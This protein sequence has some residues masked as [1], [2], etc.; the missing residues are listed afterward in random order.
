MCK[1]TSASA[2]RPG[3]DIDWSTWRRGF[4]L[5]KRKVYLK[6]CAHAAMAQS[7]SAAAGAYLSVR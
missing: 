3:Q 6:S 1:P 7:V 2:P 4:P 5:L